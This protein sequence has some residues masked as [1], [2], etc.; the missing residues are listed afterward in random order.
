MQG[1]PLTAKDAD[2]FSV[3]AIYNVQECQIFL[4]EVWQT[5]NDTA[6]L[7]SQL[8][9]TKL[10]VCLQMKS[11]V[12]FTATWRALPNICIIIWGKLFS[13]KKMM[14]QLGML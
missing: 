13:C 5:A 1:K 4:Q 2:R 7:L 10:R 9:D 11:T 6:N 12:R 14:S 3:P 8:P